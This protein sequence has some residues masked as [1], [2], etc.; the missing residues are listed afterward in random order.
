MK[1]A[2]HAEQTDTSALSPAK[3][4]LMAAVPE[5]CPANSARLEHVVWQNL[6]GIVYGA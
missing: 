3:T 6:R 4:Q 1:G 5:A 2:I